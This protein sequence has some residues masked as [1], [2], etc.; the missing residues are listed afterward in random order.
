MVAAEL[1]VA[2]GMAGRIGVWC[3]GMVEG[4]LD[5]SCE[6]GP[7]PHR[8]KV[9]VVAKDNTA[10]VMRALKAAADEAGRARAAGGEP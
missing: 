1:A 6:H 2:V 4:E 7:P 3:D 10:A 8:V 5:H 9:C